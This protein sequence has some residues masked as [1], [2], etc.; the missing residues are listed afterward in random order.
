MITWIEKNSL[1]L[2]LLIWKLSIVCTATTAVYILLIWQTT[3]KFQSPASQGLWLLT[4]QGLI[5]K[6][7][8]GEIAM[9]KQGIFI[10]EALCERCKALKTFLEQTIGFAS[11]PSYRE[12]LRLSYSMNEETVHAIQSY[13]VKTNSDSSAPVSFCG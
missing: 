10:A 13:L 4:D 2:I 6:S 1:F 8:C 9:T 7:P 3:F 11:Q 12:I 5:Q